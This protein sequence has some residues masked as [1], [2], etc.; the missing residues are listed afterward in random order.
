MF[1]SF[2]PFLL[3]KNHFNHMISLRI[4]DKHLLLGFNISI[5]KLPFILCVVQVHTMFF[6]RQLR[7][8]YP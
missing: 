8:S 7:I 5:Y 2:H 4:I 3:A 1:E 6:Y